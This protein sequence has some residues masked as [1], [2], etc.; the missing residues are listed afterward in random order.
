M[1]VVVTINLSY[2][3]HYIF[4]TYLYHDRKAFCMNATPT[5][6]HEFKFP[7]SCTVISVFYLPHSCTVI[8]VREADEALLPKW[9]VP[10][11]YTNFC[12]TMSPKKHQRYQSCSDGVSVNM[13]NFFY[14]LIAI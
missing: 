13:W 5:L 4:W 14:M 2:L 11:G 6:Y 10:T 1:Q 7:H 9:I 3:L 12:L 8:S